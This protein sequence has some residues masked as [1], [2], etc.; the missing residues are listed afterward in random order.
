MTTLRPYSLGSSRSKRS[1]LPV[2]CLRCIEARSW[3]RTSQ[4]YP[5]TCKLGSNFRLTTSAKS[6]GKANTK[7]GQSSHLKQ[8]TQGLSNLRIVLNKQFQSQLQ[9]Q[10]EWNSKIIGTPR[11]LSQLKRTQRM[12]WIIVCK[13]SWVY[14][15]KMNSLTGN[16]LEICPPLV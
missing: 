14:H 8:C 4:V 2:R 12:G 13:H 1:S 11:R 7:S 9:P 5:L 3:Q 15:R 6:T 10:G 16:R